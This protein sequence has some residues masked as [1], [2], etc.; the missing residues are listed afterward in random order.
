MQY[1]RIRIVWRL[2]VLQS[3][4]TRFI[5]ISIYIFFLS[6]AFDDKTDKYKRCN[7]MNE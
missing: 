4:L 1:V 2:H 6:F 3:R 7:D 5:F